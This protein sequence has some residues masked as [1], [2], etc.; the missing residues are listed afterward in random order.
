MRITIWSMVVGLLFVGTLV[1]AQ[2]VYVDLAAEMDT[3]VLVESGGTG[4]TDPLDEDIGWVDAGTLPRSYSDGSPFT[5][6]DGRT[7]FLFASLLQSSLDGAAM[8]GQ[9]LDVEDGVYSSLDLAMLAAPGSFGNPFTQ[10]ELRYAD[11]T[12]EQKR[13]GPVAGWFASPHAFDNTYYNYTDSSGVETIV[14]FDTDWGDEELLYLLQ[15]RGNGNAGGNRFVDGNGFALYVIEDIPPDLTDATLGV[16]V[17]N[18]FVISLSAEYWD[19]EVSTTEGYE[20][21]AN[22][23][24]IHDGFEHRALGNLR[25]Y[26]FD[27]S[28]FLAQ[29]TGELYIL[30]T[31][32]TP[33]N[34][35]GPYIQNISLYTGE[36]LIFE[37][38]L[39][40]EVDTSDAT[41]YAMFQ[42]DG[43]DDEK[44]YLY[45]NSGSGPSNRQH[46]FADGNGSITYQFDLPDDADDAQLTVDMANNF[47]V[48]LSGPTGI[49]RYDYITPNSEDE[50]DYLIDEG[51]SILGDGFRFADAG[52]YMVYQFDLPNDITAAV[53]Q[54]N[55]GNQFV[56]EAA[57]GTDGDFQIEMDWVFDTGQ[58][59]RDN[60]NLDMYEI[61]LDDYLQDNPENII[62]FRFSDGIPSD[63][64]GP[65]F[66]GMAIVN[67]SGEGDVE[68]QEVLNSM[69]IF[70]E[71]IHGEYNK[72][73]YTIDLA[74]VLSDNPTKEFFVRFTDASTGDGW[75]PGIFWMA[76]YS[77]EINIQSD[78]Y[79]FNG[80]KATNG[81]PENYG[82]GLIHRRYDANASKTLS[83]I[84][85]AGEGADDPLPVYLLAATLNPGET[86]V[87]DWMIQ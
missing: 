65:Y 27:V 20:V 21:V 11:G 19:P 4:L 36:N 63:G 18:N 78:R 70:G 1:S 13:L 71:D 55:I 42:T 67:Q 34:G 74:S 79:V 23:M 46:R 87:V 3:D 31:D 41:V 73:F 14:S 24:E 38:L 10:I 64:W 39:T 8:N 66:T 26:E 80:L 62:R 49:E 45:D 83:E 68:Y 52:N 81:E 48:S 30:F 22:S 85:L 56:I 50:S 76:V 16:T 72:D 2:P 77:G 5:T 86:N 28:P 51:G 69:E 33:Q 43:G 75:G 7:S 84:R 59:T 58:E 9:V 6:Q 35:W 37:E 47:V 15:E 54:I 61:Q 44:L 82:I 57:P 25:L 12:T 29:Q 32:A 17:G 53:A 40:P 60:S